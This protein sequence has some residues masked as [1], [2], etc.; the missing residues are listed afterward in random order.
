MEMTRIGISIPILTCTIG[1]FYRQTGGPNSSEALRWLQKHKFYMGQ[2]SVSVKQDSFSALWT[3]AQMRVARFSNDISSKP[4][5][6]QGQDVLIRR[7]N[8][9]CDQ[10]KKNNWCGITE[11]DRGSWLLRTFLK[12]PLKMPSIFCEFWC[13]NRKLC[14]NTPISFFS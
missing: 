9:F 14:V 2:I 6:W 8:R 3:K 4:L 5:W 1:A 10:M 12:L 13:Y 7:W 11:R